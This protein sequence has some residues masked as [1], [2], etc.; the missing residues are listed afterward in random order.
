MFFIESLYEIERSYV[1]LDPQWL[2]QRLIGYLFCPEE[3]IEIS[4][5]EDDQKRDLRKFYKKFKKNMR[6]KADKFSLSTNQINEL[7]LGL[8]EEFGSNEGAIAQILEELNIC[9]RIGVCEEEDGVEE[10]KGEIGDSIRYFPCFTDQLCCEGYEGMKS[11]M[12]VLMEGGERVIGRR[13]QI[14]NQDFMFVPGFF[15]SL[16]AEII[17][18]FKHLVG[19]EIWRDCL[20]V[21]VSGGLIVRLEIVERDHFFDMSVMIMRDRDYEKSIFEVLIDLEEKLK[22]RK[23]SFFN[24]S[25]EV[26]G[27]LPD[28]LCHSLFKEDDKIYERFFY[29]RLEEQ[30]EFEK[31]RGKSIEDWF[32][33]LHETLN[34]STNQIQ[35]DI[36]DLT[37]LQSI[38]S[39]IE[40]EMN[41]NN[42]N[43]TS[44]SF[45]RFFQSLSLDESNHLQPVL[46]GI[47]NIKSVMVRCE[48]ENEDQH[49]VTQEILESLQNQINQ[50]IK[51][52][53]RDEEE[54][55]SDQIFVQDQDDEMEDR[56]VRE[57]FFSSS[58]QLQV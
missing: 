21:Q 32:S 58:N 3:M 31:M 14:S 1:V 5:L 48:M 29:D 43:P 30:I 40:E 44:S 9:V 46:N 33:F 55:K 28:P 11:G 7:C 52:H 6:G 12:E 47:S 15:P 19:C 27:L 2:S 39:K 45:D 8:N 22:K 17:S 42:N 54:M 13:Y 18:S 4:C 16:F 41:Q 57:E 26:K 10:K 25:I 36:Q 34:K 24:E 37:M 53:D 49:L 56:K 51:N 35:S 38:S 20:K 23:E 50:H